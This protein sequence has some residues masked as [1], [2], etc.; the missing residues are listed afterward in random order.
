MK[1]EKKNYPQAYLE[2]RKYKIKKKK[3]SRFIYAE[4]E[5]D[6]DSYSEYFTKIL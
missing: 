1:I 3:M 5:L 2:Q 6:L 4:L